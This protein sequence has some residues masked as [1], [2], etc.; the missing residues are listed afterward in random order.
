MKLLYPWRGNYPREI[1][2][3]KRSWYQEAK[4]K[5][6]PFWGKPYMDFDSVSGLSLPCS[7]PIYDLRGEFRGV[8]G[9]DLSIN[10]L[11]ESILS[12]GNTGKYV[13]E[14]AVINLDG[15]TIFSSQSE[16]FNKKFDPAKYHRHVE[17]MTPLFRT[18]AIRKRITKDNR[19][20]GAFIVRENGRKIIYSLAHLDIWN[21]YFVVVADY[22]ELV[23]HIESL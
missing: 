6:G 1:D 14:K 15:E 4:L 5:K 20:Y 3:R 22:D 17:F 11:T 12:K 13:I 18:E 23:R 9:L 16:Y 19:G 21:M 2:P 7:V 10:K 8:V